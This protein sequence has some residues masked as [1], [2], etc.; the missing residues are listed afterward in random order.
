MSEKNVMHT[1]QT[2]TLTV[3][4][5][6]GI[7]MDQIYHHDNPLLNTHLSVQM[8]K[9][10]VRLHVLRLK[11]FCKTYKQTKLDKN[12]RKS[13]SKSILFRNQ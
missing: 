6:K 13:L 1:M 7:E 9:N 5:E 11:H 8:V 4:R 12:I 10:L 3:L 2:A